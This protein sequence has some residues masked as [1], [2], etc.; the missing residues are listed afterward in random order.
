MQYPR[1]NKYKDSGVEWISEIPNDWR[2]EKIRA[3]T[4]LKSEKKNPRLQVL[5][6]Y[7]DYGVIQKDSRDD[8]HNVTSQDTSTYKVVK[9]GDLVVNKMKAWQG[10]MGV[11]EFEGIVSPAYITCKLK[12]EKIYPKYLHYLLRSHIYIGVY[13]A[14]SYGVRVGQWDMHYEDFKKIP[15][16]LPDKETM[17][18]IVEFLDNKLAEIDEAISKKVKLIELLKEQKAILINRAV[19]RGL[20]PDVKLKDSGVEW[21]GKI[22]EHWEIK[23]IKYVALISPS[24]RLDNRKKTEEFVTFLPMEKITEDGNYDLSSKAICKDVFD[25]FTY[26]AK[27]DVAI[28]KITPCFE[29]GKGAVINEL[30][31][32][33]G[34]GTTELHVF[35]PKKITGDYLYYY[36]N[37]KEFLLHGEKFMIGTAGQKR[38]PIDFISNYFIPLPPFQ[39]QIEICS[40]I[41]AKKKEYILLIEKTLDEIRK[42]KEY[43][44]ILISNVVTGKIKVT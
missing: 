23:K 21:I 25:G 31:S 11:S 30:D 12:T 39:E 29:N 10:S 5:S 34:F 36:L 28:A 2:I 15:I 32:D 42:M 24:R 13:N 20:D 22:P 37:R 38:I 7:R 3:V 4:E 8:N 41:S 19:T 14:L 27:G 18:K 40:F 17:I 43:K 16:C 44:S 33:F 6:V 26:F 1:Y 35:R 9:P